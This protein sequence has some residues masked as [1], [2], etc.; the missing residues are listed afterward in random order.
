MRSGTT[1]RPS[2]LGSGGMFNCFSISSIQFPDPYNWD[3]SYG[4]DSNSP[5]GCDA[6]VIDGSSVQAG[7]VAICVGIRYGAISND[8]KL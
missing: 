3:R 7:A 5:G 1:F 4:A 2:Y 6:S 8:M